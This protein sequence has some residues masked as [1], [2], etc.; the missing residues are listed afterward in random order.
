MTPS[1]WD[2]AEEPEAIEEPE[3]DGAEETEGS[4]AEEVRGAE[5]E[6][7]EE[8]AMEEDEELELLSLRLEHAV[9][10]RAHVIANIPAIKAF[11]KEFFLSQ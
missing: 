3:E 8:D 6:G 5:E 4:D 2:E 7:A 10:E 11:I 1:L 9:M